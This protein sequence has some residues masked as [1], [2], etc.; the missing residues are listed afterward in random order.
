[1]KGKN[2]SKPK[3]IKDVEEDDNMDRPF[4]YI[5]TVENKHSNFESS[6]IETSAAISSVVKE[7][8]NRDVTDL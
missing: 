2:T 3:H 7:V 6:T 5:A 8:L 4:S 1:M